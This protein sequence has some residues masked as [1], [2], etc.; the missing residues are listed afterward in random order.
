MSILAY[1][2]VLASMLQDYAE[3]APLGENMTSIGNRLDTL[4]HNVSALRKDMVSAE[5]LN[6]YL[7]QEA[8]IPF[9][10][11]CNNNCTT[12]PKM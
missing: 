11:I 9:E 8:S 1:S 3:P 4:T 5:V 6:L 7:N 10:M 12:S 2:V